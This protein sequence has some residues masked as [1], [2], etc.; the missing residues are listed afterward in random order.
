MLPRR[1]L[2][3]FTLAVCI[4]R[5]IDTEFLK[6][7]I[8]YIRLE[9]L[10]PAVQLTA[11]LPCLID[12]RRQLSVASCKHSF[13]Y[14]RII[15]APAHINTSSSLWAYNI[16]QIF[17]PFVYLFLCRLRL[18]F[19]WC[20]GLRYK[21]WKR[22]WDAYRLF[23]SAL[24]IVIEVNY[25]ICKLLYRLYII[26]RFCR[27]TEHKVQLDRAVS[28]LK[29]NLTAFEYSFLGDILVYNVTQT[30][31]ACLGSKCK[32]A[33]SHALYLLYDLVAEFI[34]TQWR[35]RKVYAFLIG[36]FGYIVQKPLNITVVAC[37]QWWKRYLVIACGFRKALYLIY[38]SFLW[39]F[40]ERTIYKA[41]LTESA[42]SDTASQHLDYRS[43]VYYLGI[44]HNKAVRSIDLVKIVYNLLS[45][46]CGGV[47]L[48]CYR[49]YR[50]VLI[51]AYIIEWRNIDSLN[52][53]R[54]FKIF[55]LRAAVLLE[56]FGKLH[57]LEVYFLAFTEYEQIKEIGYRLCITYAGTA[58]HYYREQILSVFS[59]NR[60][61]CKVKH[62]QDICIAKLILERKA[63]KLK[64]LDGIKAFQTVKRNIVLSHLFFHIGKG[65]EHTFAPVI[66]HAVL[67]GI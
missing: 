52:L 38:Y 19:K 31:W 17:L 3:I 61:T 29:G 5:L 49:F 45:D 15:M 65:H 41:C 48:R 55:L 8:P 51:I 40:S 10:V 57:H 37:G 21:C 16:K 46:F 23:A 59:K 4:E 13:K 43:V 1:N 2:V 18:I 39:F 7:R 56:L 32:S 22:D 62:R 54:L 47:I 9:I 26:K 36:I 6:C 14:C 63:D 60:H 27:Q 11:V 35:E 53:C 42:A 33:S 20:E 24:C 67:E 50:S 64:I 28:A 66:R 58:A 34:Y 30:L 44:R 12:N 25:L